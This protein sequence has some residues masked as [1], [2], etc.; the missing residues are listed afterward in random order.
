[1]AVVENELARIVLVPLGLNC[2]ATAFRDQTNDEFANEGGLA[3]RAGN[4][5]GRPGAGGLR[6]GVEWD[7]ASSSVTKL[8]KNRTQAETNMRMQ[9]TPRP[10]RG[11]TLLEVLMAV[12]LLG[13]M[14][15]AIFG[16]FR[17]GFF[18]L[19]L[20]R[21]NQRATQIMLEKV[22]TIRLY[23]WDQ[24]NSNGFIP[25]TFT[26]VYD[27][28]AGTNSQGATYQGTVQITA[29]PLGAS[30]AANMRQLTVTLNWTTH[31]VPHTRSVTTYVAKDGIQNYVY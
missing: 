31:D 5:L 15:G 21:E 28:Q 16:S 11:M 19:Q 1:M 25:A 22:E 23:N 13:I 20:V 9:G 26:D 4:A 14:S 30:Y 7:I 24:V 6:S 2:D 10:E 29:C 18:L 17:Y 8:P 3:Q 27:P 12:A